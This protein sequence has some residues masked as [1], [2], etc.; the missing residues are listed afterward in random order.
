MTLL[1]NCISN[2]HN[3]QNKIILISVCSH[4]TLRLFTYHEWWF[5]STYLYIWCRSLLKLILYLQ[6]KR[7]WKNGSLKKKM[8]TDTHTQKKRDELCAPTSPMYFAWYNFDGKCIRVVHP[9]DNIFGG[10]WYNGRKALWWN[11]QTTEERQNFLMCK[12]GYLPDK[13]RTNYSP[14]GINSS[15]V[16]LNASTASKMC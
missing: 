12:Y 16:K 5:Y 14:N 11:I 15:K 9:V 7:G 4:S 6:P 1:A 13:V 2:T 3:C 10:L 8:H